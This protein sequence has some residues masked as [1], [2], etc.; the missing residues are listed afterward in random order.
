MCH[1]T[2]LQ[3]TSAPG[4]SGVHI[5]AHLSY[6]QANLSK[7]ELEKQTNIKIALIMENPE[8][9]PSNTELVAFHEAH[10]YIVI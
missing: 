2:W 3:T 9:I 8:V 4:C 7:P 6:S 10:W 1:G 5:Q